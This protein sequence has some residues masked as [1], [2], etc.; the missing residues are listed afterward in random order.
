[1]RNS[2]PLFLVLLSTPVMADEMFIQLRMIDLSIDGEPSRLRLSVVSLGPHEHL[3]R[4]DVPVMLL[5]DG[6]Y[7]GVWRHSLD[8]GTLTTVFHVRREEDG[9]YTGDFGTL[10]AIGSFSGA[11]GKGI[12]T[13]LRGF[14]GASS[15]TGVHQIELH[16]SVP[17]T[18]GPPQTAVVR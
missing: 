14:E 13:T 7:V 10:T 1:M 16:L 2:L 4:T 15:P 18:D 5:K 12:L 3:V 17:L 8:G 6:R 9:S 11:H